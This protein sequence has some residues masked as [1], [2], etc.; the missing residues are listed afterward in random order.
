[1]RKDIHIFPLFYSFSIV[2]FFV[3]RLISFYEFSFA[4]SCCKFCILLF[5]LFLLIKCV[6]KNGV[7]SLYSLFIPESARRPS[8]TEG[9][10]V[11]LA[12]GGSL[13]VL[14]ADAAGAAAAVDGV[15]FALGHVAADAGIGLVVFL[16][17]GA[18]LFSLNCS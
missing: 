15:V 13:L 14:H 3:I 4:Y 1:M 17:H 5:F 16:L 10:A 7:L 6:K 9:G 2:V 8:G 11:G 18:H 12:L